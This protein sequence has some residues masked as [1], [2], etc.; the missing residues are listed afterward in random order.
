LKNQIEIVI[1]DNSDSPIAEN[2]L[3][4]I[5]T[6]F[7]NVQYNNDEKFLTI[8]DNFTIGLKACKGEWIVF[9]GDDDFFMPSI[10]QS[11]KN[12]LNSGADCIIYNPHKYYWKNCIFTN[13]NVAGGQETLV[14]TK[15]WEHKK[16]NP[17]EELRKSLKNGGLTIEKMPRAYHGIIKQS[18]MKKCCL[19]TTSNEM[20]LGSPDI[21]MA[22]I[23]SS[24]NISVLS[25]PGSPTIYGASSGSGGG[26]TTSKT[27]VQTLDKASFL[28]K[29]FK[30]EWNET[31]PKYWSEYTVFPASIL[32]VIDQYN[33]KLPTKLNHAA[34]YISCLFY[35][36]K[37]FKDIL[38]SFN[39]LK[40]ADLFNFL[41][42]F[43][44]TLVRK[45]GGIFIRRIVKKKN[46]GTFYSLKPSEI[47][48]YD[49]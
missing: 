47:I 20:L 48:K 6:I 28:S 8:S 41:V 25:I 40:F 18:V 13:K 22:T 19:S 46:T 33:L 23:L 36:I 45:I 42:K 5:K 35:E 27:H 10:I 7:P 34:I 9:I 14:I 11:I 44:F 2:L 32:Y 3:E 30:D 21:S 37:Y 39:S 15:S 29:S 16:I 17:I 31:V 1:S 38:H 12:N 49:F 4:E 43:P 26:M 24:S